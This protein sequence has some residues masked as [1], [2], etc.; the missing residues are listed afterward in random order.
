MEWHNVQT[1]EMQ[2]Q[3]KW[4]LCKG[5]VLYLNINLV[6]IILVVNVTVSIA[7]CTYVICDMI[8]VHTLTKLLNFYPG[9]EYTLN[10]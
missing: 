9:F 10:L 2:Y 7:S 1:W 5:S 6:I 8:N 3:G 4:L